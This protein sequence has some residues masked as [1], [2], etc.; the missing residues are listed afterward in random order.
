MSSSRDGSTLNVLLVLPWYQSGAGN[1]PGL[2]QNYSSESRPSADVLPIFF[3]EQIGDAGEHQQEQHHPDTETLT[4]GLCR[5]AYVLKKVDRVAHHVVVFGGVQ[6]A[7]NARLELHLA[8]FSGAE[9]L[10]ALQARKHVRHGCAEQRAVVHTGLAT[11][12]VRVEAG[13]EIEHPVRTARTG[14][15][16]KIGRRL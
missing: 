9:L 6:L 2:A 15:Q 13:Q 12:G 11:R 1:C 16:R 5:I 3:L 7:G 10:D 4:L 8:T 14:H